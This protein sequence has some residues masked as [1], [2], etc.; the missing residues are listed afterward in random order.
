MSHYLRAGTMFDMHYQRKFSSTL[1]FR[2]NPLASQL[3]PIFLLTFYMLS[4]FST[5]TVIA[6][7]QV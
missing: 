5:F 6:V 7:T 4:V 2:G 1:K 3:S